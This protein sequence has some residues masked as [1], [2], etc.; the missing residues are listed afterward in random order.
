MGYET[1]LFIVEKGNR[2]FTNRKTGKKEK[3]IGE[4]INGKEM[5]Y[6]DLIASFDLCK[7][8]PVSDAMR[9]YPDT[10]SYIYMDDGNTKLIEDRY[11]EPLKEIPL[12]DAVEI[13]E[14][15]ASVEDYR[16]FTPCL[17]LLEALYNNKD[18]WG[19]IV[20]LHYGY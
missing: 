17:A 9:R 1:K 6:A 11:G 19:E 3:F 5:F 14:E 18:K 4:I 8:Y 2:F 15:A 7:C 20:V 12:A 16:R 13:L 10:D